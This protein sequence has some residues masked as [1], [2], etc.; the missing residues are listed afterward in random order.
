MQL[1]YNNKNYILLFRMEIL[2]YN[3]YNIIL[4]D[5]SQNTLTHFLNLIIN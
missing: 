1:L 2:N 5:D 4:E 3:V